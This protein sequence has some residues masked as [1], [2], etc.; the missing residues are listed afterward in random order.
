MTRI[1]EAR[2]DIRPGLVARPVLEPLTGRHC[3]MIALAD[4]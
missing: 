1:E 4:T 2:L 3:D